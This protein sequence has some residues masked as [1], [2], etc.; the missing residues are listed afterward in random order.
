MAGI[1]LKIRARRRYRDS[2][3]IVLGCFSQGTIVLSR[4]FS[5]CLRIR[6]H[7]VVILVRHLCCHLCLHQLLNRSSLLLN[8]LTAHI[9]YPTLHKHPAFLIFPKPGSTV[10][11]QNTPLKYGCFTL[12]QMDRASS[13]AAAA[14]EGRA[15]TVNQWVVASVLKRLLSVKS[16]KKRGTTFT[17]HFFGCRRPSSIGSLCFRVAGR[18]LIFQ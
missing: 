11:V 13:R 4:C 15:Q 6:R 17:A 18:R 8:W 16:A 1:F 7:L 12:S 9:G 10:N 5:R 3:E 2:R 14:G